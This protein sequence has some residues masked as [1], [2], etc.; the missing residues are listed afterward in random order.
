MRPSRKRTPQDYFNVYAVPQTMLAVL[1]AVEAAAVGTAAAAQLVL[2][3]KLPAHGKRAARL[4]I[5]GG[6]DTIQRDAADAPEALRL[7]LGEVLASAAGS[8]RAQT[9]NGSSSTVSWASSSSQT[10]GRH[11]RKAPEGPSC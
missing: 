7:L 1:K 4:C 3:A 6:R 5:C 10:R 11:G 2:T 9:P 8:P